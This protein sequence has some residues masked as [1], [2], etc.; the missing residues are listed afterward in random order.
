MIKEEFGGEPLGVID[1]KGLAGD[2]SDNIPG[3]PGFGPKTAMKLLAQFGSVEGVIAGVD[4]VKNKR[5]QG[6]INEHA[7]QALLSKKL[8]TILTEVPLEFE[9]QELLVEVPELEIAVEVLTKYEFNRLITRYKSLSGEEVEEKIE[10]IIEPI[11]IDKDDKWRDL[12]AIIKWQG[13][14]V[15]ECIADKSN[16]LSDEIL[17]LG[18]YVKNKYYYV[19]MNEERIQAFK[20][21]MEDP[22]IEKIGH[23]LK[24]VYLRFFRYGIHPAGMNFDTFIA[25]YLLTPS[26]K[27]YELSDLL[28]KSDSKVIKSTEEFLGKGKKAT[29][30]SEHELEEVADFVAH[31]CY[32]IKTLKAA[33][34]ASLE[35]ESLTELYDSVEMPLVE[36]LADLEF[37]GMAVDTK[38]LDELDDLI[39]NKVETL[40]ASIYEQAGEEFNINSPKQLGV[41]LFDK[42]EMPVIK[43]TKTGYSTSH[44]V[45]ME[46]S[47][48]YDFVKEIM[49]YRTYAKLKSTYVD[50]LKAVINEASG[51]VHSSFNQTVAVTGRLSSTDPNM[52]NIP[53]RIEEGRQLRKVFV[54]KEDHQLIDADYSQIELR[55]LAHMSNDETLK[56]AYQNDIDIHALTAASVFDIELDEVT[57]HQR[58]RAKEVNFGIVYGMSDFGLS[59]NLKITRKEAKLY[60]ENYFDQYKDV[61]TY[62]ENKVKE[63][64]ETGYVTT[65]LN[66]KR[67]VPE[68]HSSNFNHR[69]FAERTAMNTPIQGSA[70]D[71]IKLAMIKVYNALK[72]GHYKSKLILQVHDELI[73]EAH[74]DEIEVIQKLLKD[75]MEEAIELIVPLKVDMSVGDNWYETK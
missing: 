24:Q 57:R 2:A 12:R 49:D 10:E 63:C 26:L 1:Y 40:T 47:K 61:K 13:D 8:A 70:A 35:E 41:I 45:L 5:W 37:T 27:T 17:G 59:E 71:I 53:I 62:M 54:A 52:Q 48:D 75:N 72:D 4:E 20:T 56:H 65:I 64:K 43:K 16:V 32:A 33:Y 21:I 34:K 19:V 42:L 28:V 22:K 14:F 7:E 50:G 67:Y 68:I 9:D 30:F 55:V 23:E 46:L 69:S 15:L 58:S 39:T 18:I 31:Q 3:I 25:G 66:R 73:I 38:T 29:Q 51:R 44:D 11:I 6:L 60:I 74:K 36:V